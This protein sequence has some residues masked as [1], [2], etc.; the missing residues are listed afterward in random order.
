M[1]LGL[2]LFAWV[3][4]SEFSFLRGILGVG[5]FVA[6]GAIVASIL[7]GFTLGLGFSE[8]MVGFASAA[9]LYQ[10]GQVFQTYRTDQHV[11]AALTLFASIALLL[12]YVVRIVAA[13]D[14]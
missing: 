13:G 12:W 6:V 14:D 5:C 7:F 2:T 9:I 10:T 11:A 8:I 3:S 1:A 4:G